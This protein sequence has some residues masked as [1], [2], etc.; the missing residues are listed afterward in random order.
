MGLHDPVGLYSH[1]SL[2]TEGRLL[3]LAG[4]VSV[5]KGGK[6]VGIGDVAVQTKQVFENIGT[7]FNGTNADFGDVFQFTIYVVGTAVSESIFRV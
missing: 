7:I 4:Q 1:L 3:Y 5:G 2:V 6:V